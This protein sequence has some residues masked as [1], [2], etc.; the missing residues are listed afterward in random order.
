MYKPKFK[1]RKFRNLMLYLAYLCREDPYFGAVKLNKM[2]YYCDFIAFSRL[3]EPITGASYQKLSEG[4]APR[5]LLRERNRLIEAEE[6]KLELRPY[7]AYVQQRLVPIPEDQ[8]HLEKEFSSEEIGVITEVHRAML[9]MTARDASEL[10]HREVGWILAY[11][12][13]IIPYEMAAAV[14]VHD[15]EVDAMF[16]TV[17]GGKDR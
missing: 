9:H 3:G 5:L 17:D 4:P 11:P 1:S 10:S 14:P 2:L 16:E 15:A 8:S 13:E 7:F 6:A 12:G